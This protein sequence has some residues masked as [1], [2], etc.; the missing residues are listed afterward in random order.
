MGF[1][2]ASLGSNELKYVDYDAYRE[3]ARENALDVAD[4]TTEDD[5]TAWPLIDKWL[6]ID[7]TLD[8]NTNTTQADSWLGNLF[9]KRK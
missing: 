4:D 7:H 2:Q 6:D 1:E 9:D 5:G 3:Q 8:S